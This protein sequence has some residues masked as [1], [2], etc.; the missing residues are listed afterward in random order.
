MREHAALEK[1]VQNQEKLEAFED[2]RKRTDE[3]PSPVDAVLSRVE[4]K[5]WPRA[6]LYVCLCVCVSACLS[7]C[8]CLFVSDCV[9]V[10][11]CLR[12]CLHVCLT[13]CTPPTRLFVF[14]S[15]AKALQQFLDDHAYIKAQHVSMNLPTHTSRNTGGEGGEKKRETRV[16]KERQEKNEAHVQTWLRAGQR[17]IPDYCCED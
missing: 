11:A 9:S 12:A 1:F 10:C 8:V 6:C 13:H 15:T 2:A 14:C 4:D 17:F 16:E 7:V 5:G 3:K